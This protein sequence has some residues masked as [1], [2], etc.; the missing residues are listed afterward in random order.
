M[1]KL[2]FTLALML[3]L[4]CST[5]HGLMAQDTTALRFAGFSDS[6]DLVMFKNDTSNLYFPL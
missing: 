6:G 5:G 3:L 1:R 4:T 2:K